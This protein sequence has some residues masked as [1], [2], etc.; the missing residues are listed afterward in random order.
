MNIYHTIPYHTIP[1]HTSCHV[2]SCHVISHHMTS[3]IINHKSYIIISCH[4]ITSQQ[5][6]YNIS[7]SIS[8][9]I[10]RYHIIYHI[11]YHIISIIPECLQIQTT[12]AQSFCDNFVFCSESKNFSTFCIQTEIILLEILHSV[13]RNISKSSYHA[14]PSYRNRSSNCIY[15]AICVDLYLGYSGFCGKYMSSRIAYIICLIKCRIYLPCKMVPVS[16]SA[17]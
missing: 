14:Y 10:I 6:I 3:Y 17:T 13:H 11:S 7:Y 2:L 16:Q 15:Q 1:Y 5:I 4:H 9:H 12:I 8:Y